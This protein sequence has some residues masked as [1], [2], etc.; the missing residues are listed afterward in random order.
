M[1]NKTVY[2]Y[3]L[4]PGLFKLSLP[5]SFWPLHVGARQGGCVLWVL[6][7]KYEGCE[8][9]EFFCARTGQT[10]P[11][12]AWEHL[13][14]VESGIVVHVFLK[15]PV[16]ETLQ[17]PID[18]YKGFL[19]LEELVLA[20]KALKL[21]ELRGFLASYGFPKAMDQY[22][23]SGEWKGRPAGWED[24]QR[25]KKTQLQKTIGLLEGIQK[26]GGCFVSEGATDEP[27]TEI[28]RLIEDEESDT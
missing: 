24:P 17:K 26:E 18:L 4:A 23:A 1:S 25:V 5:K 12:G 8:E 27:L 7:D 22:I 11:E 28:N 19:A 10:L 16:I 15:S 6:I 20:G 9:F 2:K 13:G 21:S 3:A 14:T